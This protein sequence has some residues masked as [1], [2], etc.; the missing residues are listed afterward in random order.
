MRFE[1]SNNNQIRIEPIAP[2]RVSSTIIV[3]AVDGAVSGV[4]VS[5]DI[6]HTFTSDL[7]ITLKSPDGRSV[8]LVSREGGSGNH[9]LDTVFDDRSTSSIVNARPPFTGRF[10]PDQPLSDLDGAVA[11]GAWTF[12]IEDEQFQDG[13]FLLGWTL[14]FT[15]QGEGSN[16]SIDV[17][18]QGGLSM[19]Q[20]R[21]FSNAA[22]RWSEIITGDADGS[23]LEVVIE[24]EGIPIDRGGVP[25]FSR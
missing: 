16:F 21:V 1:F 22:D 10:R 11:N 12:E 8:R 2:T 3:D 25:G 9:F 17:D 7:V 4:T 18:F 15:A 23:E 14:G 6:L 19:S 20:Q 24:A 5:F 13:G